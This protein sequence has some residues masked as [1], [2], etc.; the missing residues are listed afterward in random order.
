MEEISIFNKYDKV[1][2]LHSERTEWTLRVRAQAIWKGVNRVTQ[3]FR[4]LNVIFVDDSNW[5]IHAFVSSKICVFFDD[6]LKEGL[7][8]TLSNFHVREYGTEDNNRAVRFGKHIYF[9]N[10][11]QLIPEAENTTNVALYAFDLFP[12]NEARSLLADIRFLF[13]T[14]GIL[15]DKNIQ[16]VQS[17][18]DEKKIHIRFKISDGRSSMNVTFFGDLAV[19][20]A[21]SVK[22]IKDDTIT[23]IIASAK[24]NEHEG[25][26]CLN[27]YPATRFYLN[28]KHPSVKKLKLRMSDPAYSAN[29][30]EPLPEQTPPLFSVEDIKKLPKEFIE[31]KVRCQITVKRVDEKSNWYDNV[32]TTCQTEVTTVEGRYR[33]ILCSRNVPFP[34]KR[35]RIAT[36]C[37][38]TTG[39]IA[40]IF[41]DDEIQR[42]V[43]KN[44][45]EVE[46]EL[47]DENKFPLLLKNFEKKDY[48]ITLSINERNVNKT[49]NIYRA[50]DISDP[51]E[52]LGN[53]SPPNLAAVSL[54][55]E[56]LVTPAKAPVL[57]PAKA[58]IVE[59]T[60]NGTAPDIQCSIATDTSPPTANSTNKVRNRVKK[61]D[62]RCEIE[63]DVPLGKFKILKTDKV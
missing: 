44:A 52:V 63:D 2:H 62:V 61:N 3:E 34:D 22:A 49:S 39:I 42:I 40:I 11:T 21:N 5:R 1:Q 13:D 10:H 47:G 57:N 43:G 26:I 18:E 55:E 59:N 17:K 12:L 4:G 28:A 29:H 15:E 31:K 46:D 6:I 53:H 37:N 27:N 58:P 24:V 41:P 16:P 60:N 54:T 30:L 19:E 38:D 56:P 48:L 51:I 23:V 36:L 32:C 20:F 50:T 14:V 35:F 45:F 7:I 8:Y 9:A 33:C 25:I